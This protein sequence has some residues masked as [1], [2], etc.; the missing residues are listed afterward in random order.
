MTSFPGRPPS[1]GKV[2]YHIRSVPDRSSAS[3]VGPKVLS[4]SHGRSGSS[5]WPAR[6][7]GVT[8][9]TMPRRSSTR[10]P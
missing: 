1:G 5:T 8:R 10:P 6:C 9:R 4:C 3:T 7:G 2:P